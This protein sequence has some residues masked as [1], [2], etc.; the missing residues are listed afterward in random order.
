MY[1]ANNKAKAIVEAGLLSAL[2]VIIMLFSVYIPIFI[3]VGNFLLPIPVAILYMKYDYKTTILSII[4]STILIAILYSPFSALSAGITY[5]IIGIAL[6][7]CFK[8]SK[9]TS[10]T[11]IILTLASIL[12]IVL[13]N[14]ILLVFVDKTTIGN[15]INQLLTTFKETANTLRSYYKSAG[16]DTQSIEPLLK[17]W[18]SI[19]SKMILSMIP[20]FLVMSGFMS[21]VIN[22]KISKAILKKL[23]YNIKDLKP[24]EEIYVDNRIIA[25][26][27]VIVC[28]GI[29]LSAQ[30]YLIGTIILNSSISIT[31]LAFMVI[32][33]SVSYY[34]LKRKFNM[35]KATI[36]IIFIFMFLAQLY[37][38]LIYV[39]I[40]DVILDFRKVDPN[41]IFKLKK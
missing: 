4:V 7:H 19:D 37:V 5:G 31:E 13:S 2:I 3:L 20:A 6:G 39:G 40:M 29:I 14:L 8:K 10:T 38:I 30:N 36:I 23:R 32:G 15:S 16:M 18:E 35:K 34:Y 26:L 25:A 17:M 27:V 9:N 1:H 21:A 11:F 22:Y 12:A 41:R 28:L 33:M 24:F